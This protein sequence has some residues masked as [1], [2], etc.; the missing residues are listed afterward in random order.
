MTLIEFLLAVL[1]VADIVLDWVKIEQSRRIL[2]AQHT[3]IAQGSQRRQWIR[4]EHE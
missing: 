4:Q 1:I 2:D 3:L